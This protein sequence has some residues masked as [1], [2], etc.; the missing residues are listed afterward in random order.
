MHTNRPTWRTN[1]EQR[2]KVNRRNRKLANTNDAVT[3][4][5]LNRASQVKVT[6]TLK[7]ISGV[8]KQDEK[9]K[10]LHPYQIVKSG[11]WTAKLKNTISQ[12]FL[13]PFSSDLDTRKLYNL[14][15]G[16]P[17]DKSNVSDM[18][19]I[20]KTGKDQYKEFVDNRLLKDDEKFHDPLTQN[21]INLIKS[22]GKRSLLKRWEMKVH[23]SNLKC[24]GMSP[25][26]ISKDW[27]TYRFQDNITVS[28]LFSG[29]KS[30]Q[31]RWFQMMHSE[32]QTNRNFG[33]KFHPA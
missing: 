32:E 3:K 12:D 16:I 17:V 2:C 22:C 6:V 9:Y 13:D 19:N 29:F 30:C 31:S 4:W 15:S 10:L 25:G 33:K 7:K 23:R 5:T 27:P 26:T 11:K 21:K 8:S 14:S 1:L 20:L 18:V 28:P 24:G